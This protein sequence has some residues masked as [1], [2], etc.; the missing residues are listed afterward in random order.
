MT[1]TT[2]DGI[3]VQFTPNASGLDR[4]MS[5]PKRKLGFVKG[6]PVELAAG[7]SVPQAEV[8]AADNT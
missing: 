1:R 4:T 2:D 7:S 5:S 3:D 8:A 6:Y